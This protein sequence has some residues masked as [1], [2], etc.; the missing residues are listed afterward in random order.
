MKGK[1]RTTTFCTL[2]S[3][4]CA[5][6]LAATH[7]GGERNVMPPITMGVFSSCAFPGLWHVKVWQ[8]L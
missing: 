8:R 4:V 3:S 7:D 5:L 1:A 6:W 2:T